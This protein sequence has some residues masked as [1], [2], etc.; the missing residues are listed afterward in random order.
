MK[1][2]IVRCVIS[3]SIWIHSDDLR[4]LRFRYY[5]IWNMVPR[6][7][8]NSIHFSTTKYQHNRK[9]FKCWIKSKIVLDKWL[10]TAK[11]ISVGCV[12]VCMCEWSISSEMKLDQIKNHINFKENA[13]Y[14]AEALGHM[15]LVELFRREIW[16][17][18]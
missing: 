9:Q 18:C 5:Y 11:S 4:T 7:F 16:E 8:P 6:H 15:A 17:Y 12:C 13:R 1:G 10:C 14:Q 2:V 3:H